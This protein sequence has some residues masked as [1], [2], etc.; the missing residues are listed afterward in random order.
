MACIF[1]GGLQALSIIVYPEKQRFFV[2]VQGQGDGDLTGVGVARGVG[3]GFL[4]DAQ[5]RMFCPGSRGN[6]AKLVLTRMLSL[7]L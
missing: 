2:F 7:V 1:R 5:E 4:G 6:R 3:Q